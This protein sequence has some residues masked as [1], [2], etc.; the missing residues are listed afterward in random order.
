MV[1]QAFRAVT[2]I[3]DQSQTKVQQGNTLIQQE[4]Y[5]EKDFHN[6]DTTK[7]TFSNSNL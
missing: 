4:N 6:S 5:L 1:R 3:F 7:P 2:N